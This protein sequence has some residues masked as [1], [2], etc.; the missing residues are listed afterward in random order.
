MGVPLPHI[1]LIRVRWCFKSLLLSCILAV[2]LIKA[3]GKQTNF[4]P[5]NVAPF[6]TSVYLLN[7]TLS[8]MSVSLRNFFI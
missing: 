7:P 4:S 5:Q 8:I 3:K 2:I 1:G 6:Y